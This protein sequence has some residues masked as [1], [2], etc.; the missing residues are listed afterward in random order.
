MATPRVWAD[1]CENEAPAVV[2]EVESTFI[3]TLL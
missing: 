1:C 3:F 2:A